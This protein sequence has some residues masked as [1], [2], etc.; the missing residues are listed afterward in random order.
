MSQI[1][2][3]KSSL[4]LI[5]ETLHLDIMEDDMHPGDYPLHLGTDVEVAGTES[6]QKDPL[7][8]V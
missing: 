7:V 4:G 1:V 3:S 2:E 5:L 6:R 8:L